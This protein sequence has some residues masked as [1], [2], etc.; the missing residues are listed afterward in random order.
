M[1]F[2]G[3]LEAVDPFQVRGWAYDPEAPSRELTVEI[4]LHGRV[5]G[6]AHANIYRKDLEHAGIGA[7]NHA[8]IYNI[9][10]K[11]A[12][13][14]LSQVAA[15]VPGTDASFETLHRVSITK[16]SEIPPAVPLCFDGVLSDNDQHPV[17]V[18]GAARSG[19]SAMAQGLLKLDRFRGHQEGHLLDLLAH[20]SVALSKFYAEKADERTPG[21]NTMVCM[22]PG[23]FQSSHWT[24]FSS[25]R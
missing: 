10:Q 14:D 24:R 2:V 19:T 11:L 4:L 22:Y 1:A 12:A 7:G 21:R 6:V 25:G 23:R 20:L 13:S 18:L 5:V 15:R 16:A 8:F 17:F 9:D 3:Y